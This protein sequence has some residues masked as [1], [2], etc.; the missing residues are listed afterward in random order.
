MVVGWEDGNSQ[1]TRTRATADGLS[2]E[3]LCS[4]GGGVWKVVCGIDVGLG[5]FLQKDKVTGNQEHGR[6]QGQTVLQFV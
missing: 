3:T 5:F 6:G 1:A 4:L 2:L